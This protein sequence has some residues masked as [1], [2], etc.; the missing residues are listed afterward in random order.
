MLYLAMCSLNKILINY[1]LP[2]NLSSQWFSSP[3]WNHIAVRSGREQN[4]SFGCYFLIGCI[5]MDHKPTPNKQRL[6]QL[7]PWIKGRSHVYISLVSIKGP[8]RWMSH[9]ESSAPLPVPAVMLRHG[10]SSSTSHSLPHCASCSRSWC[11]FWKG[12]HRDSAGCTES[13]ALQRWGWTPLSPLPSVTE[14]RQLATARNQA[15]SLLV[16][17]SARHLTPSHSKREATWSCSFPLEMATCCSQQRRQHP[18]TGGTN[19][20]KPEQNSISNYC[21]YVLCTF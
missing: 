19:R 4:R 2:E 9:S 15:G 18:Q 14:G 16:P 20:R 6:P 8:F 13:S 11:G 5:I 7:K 3:C 1:P 17:I 12:Q 10:Y 21:T